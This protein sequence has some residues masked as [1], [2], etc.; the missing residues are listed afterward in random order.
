MLHNNCIIGQFN[1]L[2]EDL[3]GYGNEINFTE[4]FFTS[5]EQ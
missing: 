2:R 5:Y 4:A 1:M 3:A